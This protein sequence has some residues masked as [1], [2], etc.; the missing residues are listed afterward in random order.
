VRSIFPLIRVLRHRDELS[1][2]RTAHTFCALPVGAME[3]IQ[4][5]PGFLLRDTSIR[6]SSASS[7]TRSVHGST[8]RITSG[9]EEIVRVRA[10]AQADRLPAGNLAAPH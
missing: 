1:G 5:A 2:N 6:L 4:S 10:I 8:Q 9:C 7:H 3:R